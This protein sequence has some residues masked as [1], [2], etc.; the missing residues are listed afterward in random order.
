MTLQQ[1]GFI[2]VGKWH[3]NG[4][5]KPK[6]NLDKLADVRVVYTFVVEG[7]VKY[8]GICDSC[9]TTLKK[10][11][12]SQ[13]FNKSMPNLIKTALE[14]DKV[15]KIFALVTEEFEYKGLKVDLM[16]GLEY[17]LIKRMNPNWNDE[18]RKYRRQK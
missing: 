17:P 7:E 6:A 9:K 8:V 11:M 4:E 1:Y 10:R 15:V 18:L 5:I 13:C 14:A 2:E 12:G 16:R 3:L